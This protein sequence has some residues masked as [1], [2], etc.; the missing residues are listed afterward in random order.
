MEVVSFVA[1]L[2]WTFYLKT[3]ITTFKVFLYLQK[4]FV[5]P[6]FT[7]AQK[8]IPFARV[9]HNK[10]MVTDET[11]YIGTAHTK[12]SYWE[13]INQ[14]SSLYLKTSEKQIRFLWNWLFTIKKVKFVVYLHFLV[15]YLHFLVV[16]LHFLVVYLWN[17]YS[18]NIL[19]LY[20]SM[21]HQYPFILMAFVWK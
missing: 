1:T 14:F 4:L 8:K 11:A 13:S 21:L 15:G 19:S 3:R 9:N 12:S 2:K 18:Y 6:A 10:Y 5:V 16:Y 7:D 20:F 17:S